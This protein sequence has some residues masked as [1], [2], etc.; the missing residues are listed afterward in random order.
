MV[1]GKKSLGGSLVEA[2]LI[3]AQQLKQAQQ[4]E[5]ELRPAVK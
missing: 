3:S 2:G 5:E 1:K 4:E